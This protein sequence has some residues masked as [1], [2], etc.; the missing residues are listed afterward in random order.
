MAKIGVVSISQADMVEEELD[1]TAK[2]GHSV[3][4]VSEFAIRAARQSRQ[5]AQELDDV[6]TRIAKKKAKAS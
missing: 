6:A 1:K 5:S 4:I 2:S 3:D